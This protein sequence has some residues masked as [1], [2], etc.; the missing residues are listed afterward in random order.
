[1]L[2][3]TG[4][5]S[6]TGIGGPGYVFRDEIDPLLRFDRPGMVAMANLGPDT[7]GSRFFITFAAAPDLDGRFTIFGHVLSGLDVLAK[8]TAYVIGAYGA[9]STGDFILNV[10]IEER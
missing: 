4:D 3:Q 2:A 5:P 1:M 8:M 6:G 10:T 7:N 9:P